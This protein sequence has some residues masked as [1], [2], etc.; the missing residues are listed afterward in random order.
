[1][2][3]TGVASFQ[4]DIGVATLAGLSRPAGKAS[5]TITNADID[6]VNQTNGQAKWDGKTEQ[7][8]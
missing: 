2:S 8:Q 5:R 1:M 3:G 7:L 6:R 4:G